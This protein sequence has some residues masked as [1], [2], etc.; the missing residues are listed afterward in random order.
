MYLLVSLT[1]RGSIINLLFIY[2]LVDLLNEINLIL[3][4]GEELRLRL[5]VKVKKVRV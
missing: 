1:K 4:I 3:A 5:K 2:F